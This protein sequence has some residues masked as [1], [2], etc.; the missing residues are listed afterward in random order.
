VVF[1]NIRHRKA[2]SPQKTIT[3]YPKAA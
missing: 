1:L 3:I 2:Q